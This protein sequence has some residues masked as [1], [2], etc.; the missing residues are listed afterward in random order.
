MVGE[1]ACLNDAVDYTG[2]SKTSRT[3]YSPGEEGY[4]PIKVTGYL[5]ENFENTSKRYQN[6]V[7]WACPKWADEVIFRKKY[8]KVSNVFLFFVFF[9]KKK[10]HTDAMQLSNSVSI[11]TTLYQLFG[12]KSDGVLVGKFRE[13]L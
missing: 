9:F 7:L 2:S 1:L 10:R 8:Q 6:L 4:S 13:H 3:A 12:H 5:S 11:V